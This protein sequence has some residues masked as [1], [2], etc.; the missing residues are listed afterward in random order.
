MDR[1]QQTKH[2]ASHAVIRNALMIAGVTF[3][4]ST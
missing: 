3:A 1:K 4:F 2:I